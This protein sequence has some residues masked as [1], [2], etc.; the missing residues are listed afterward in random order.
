MKANRTRLPGFF[1]ALLPL[2]AFVVHAQEENAGPRKMWTEHLHNAFELTSKV[3]SGAQPEDAAAFEELKKLGVKTVISVDGA[4][5]DVK[6]AKEHGLA[7]IHLPIGYDGVPK[8]RAQELA[9]AILEQ[10][11]KIFVHCHHGRHRGPAAAAVALC[12]AGDLTNDQALTVL[13]VAHTGEN[14]K[15][16]WASA[17][18]AQKGDPD[19][20]KAL[21]VTFVEVAKIPPLAEAM[22][23]VD[24]THERIEEVRKAGWRTPKDHPDLDPPHEALQLKEYFRELQRTDD[25]KTRAEDFKKWL[26]EGEDAAESL[27]K[28]LRDWK[29]KQKG[30]GEAPKA[31]DEALTRIN[32]NCSD[33][34]NVYRNAPKTP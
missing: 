12:V 25:I 27:E 33:C 2:F 19:A 26:K 22:V 21:P 31:A 9:K 29:E 16:L 23:N 11:G 13:K 32:R 1:V 18:E 15:G 3:I 30:E 17:R 6:L 7:Y 14:Y 24:V 5:P 28:V 10:P 4:T 8:G 34:H 20:L